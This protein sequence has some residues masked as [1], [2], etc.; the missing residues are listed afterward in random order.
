MPSATDP[1][2][3]ILTEIPICAPTLREPGTLDSCPP[4]LQTANMASDEWAAYDEDSWYFFLSEI[5]LRRITD[6]VADVVSKYIAA[7]LDSHDSVSIEELIPVV[8]EFE[9]QAEAFREQLPPTIKFPDVPQVASTEWKQYSRGRYYRVLELMHRP[10]L[11]TALHDPGCSP[12]VRTL[13][14]KGLANALKYLQH[15]RVN[16]RHHGTWLQL[17]NELRASTLL[18]AASKSTELRM[19]QGWDAGVAKSLAT[20]NY[21]STEFPSCKTYADVILNLADSPSTNTD[22]DMP[23]NYT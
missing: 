3:E 8:A 14:E 10:F 15:S 13:A 5:A 9:R 2:R 12:F 4:P 22:G 17:R 11:F 7:R 16:H 19:P 23:F 6:Q 18:L 20:F 21:W 1:S